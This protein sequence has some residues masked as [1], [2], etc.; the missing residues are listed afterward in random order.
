MNDIYNGWGKEIN[1]AV[2]ELMAHN[3][4]TGYEVRELI[5]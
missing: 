3:K 2:Q 4:Y 5:G 1:K